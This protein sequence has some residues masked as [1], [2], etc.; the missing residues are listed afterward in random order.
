VI[1]LAV[2]AALVAD[3]AL[4]GMLGA[5]Q[6]RPA[7]FV[8]NDIPDAFVRAE[9]KAYIALRDGDAGPYLDGDQDFLL[10]PVEI[11]VQGKDTGDAAVVEAAAWRARAVLKAAVI[12]PAGFAPAGGAGNVSIE[13]GPDTDDPDEFTFGRRLR[14]VVGL[15]EQ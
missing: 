9:S 15:I 7:V 13:S 2:Q 3:P 10:Q 4:A 5:Y 11:F 14:I 12:A 6:G 1:D 8:Q